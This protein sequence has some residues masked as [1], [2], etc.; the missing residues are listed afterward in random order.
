[1]SKKRVLITAL[2]VVVLAGLIYLQVRTWRRFEWHKFT[3]ATAGANFFFIGLGVALIY[4]DY[5]L[6]AVRWKILL[7]PVCKTTSFRLLP[8]TV[9]GFT[10][11]ALLGRPGEF[12]R[13]YLVARKESLSMAS[14]LAVWTV[15]RI[16]DVGAFAVIMAVNILLAEPRLRQ[17]PGFQNSTHRFLGLTVSA[18]LMFKISAFVILGA[19]AVAALVA[20]L[21]H[22][23][24]GQSAGVAERLV[25]PISTRLARGTAKRVHAFGEGLNTLQD[26]K[27][28]VQLTAVSLL[29]WVIIGLSYVAVTHAY[30]EPEL[31][32]M[33]LSSTLFLTAGSV[34]GGLLQLPM[35]GGG[36]QLA[37]ISILKNIFHIKAEVATSCGLMLWL[38][39]FMSIIP[40]GLVLA[41]REHVSFMKLKEESVA[42]EEKAVE[43]IG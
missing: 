33:T 9:I 7:R 4:F 19:V 28:F 11:T 35:V 1:M 42:E 8:A 14:Q 41:Q 10:S 40:A 2:V 43:K 23:N 32:E 22:K 39:T 30:A 27:S 12:I 20:F 15:E 38:V 25:R 34:A 18:F 21:I 17:L 29:I 36:S 5:Y 37:T 16:F 3:A 26:F 31:S 6:R 24:P 13:P